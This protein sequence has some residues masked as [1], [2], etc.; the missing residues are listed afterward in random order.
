MSL[1]GQRPSANPVGVYSVNFPLAND[2]LHFVSEKKKKPGV[3]LGADRAAC[4]HSCRG[5]FPLHGL[6]QWLM[7]ESKA[8]I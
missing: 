6:Q 3:M 2:E 8:S 1:S 7:S 5:D 4:G